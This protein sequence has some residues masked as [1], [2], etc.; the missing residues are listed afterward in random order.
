VFKG[1][2][3][4]LIFITTA[5]YFAKTYATGISLKPFV[6]PTKELTQIMMVPQTISI[7]WKSR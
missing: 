4:T 5:G 2:K 7:G 3:E 1:Y 6:I